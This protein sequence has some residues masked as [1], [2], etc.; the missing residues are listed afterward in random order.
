MALAIRPEELPRWV[1]G[2]LLR[3]SAGQGWKGVELRTYRYC[4]LDV[5]VPAMADFMIVSYK[6]GSTMMERRFE[7]RWTRTECHPGDVSLLTRSQASHWHWTEQ[8]DVS[9][10]YLSD[11]VVSRVAA[12]VL[13]RPI[14][15]VRLHDIL[16]TQSPIVTEAVEAISREAGGNGIGGA[17][18][19][20][21][22]STQLVVNL[23][24][25]FAS[26]QFV[27]KSG[28]GE[29]PPAIRKRIVDY[30]EARIDQPL[31]LEEL[32][33]VASMG[34][35]TFGKRFRASFQ[36]SPHQYVVDRRLEKAQQMLALGRL[37]VK[38]IASE[39]GFADQA[40]LTRVMRAR[41]GR[42]PAALRDDSSR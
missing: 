3:C 32:A 41:L 11:A 16:R 17:L 14:A 30:I 22:L 13:E 33:E 20:D 38:A 28:R 25:N 42:T 21:A 19:V 2:E 23:L 24:R 5:P 34:V 27:D 9:H 12:D 10:V 15:A 4:G 36:T 37:P 6:R 29:L 31:S 7:G 1:P 8:I 35:W 26:V 18:Y 40:H 39:C